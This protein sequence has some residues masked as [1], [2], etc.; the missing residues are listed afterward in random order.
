MKELPKE[1][2]IIDRLIHEHPE[3]VK[4][5]Y[6]NNMGFWVSKK[7][8]D[9]LVSYLEQFKNNVFNFYEPIDSFTYKCVKVLIK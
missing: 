5:L 9:D 1:F 3:Y 7:V 8:A 2:L 4:L 6:E